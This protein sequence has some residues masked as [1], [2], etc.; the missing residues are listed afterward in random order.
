ML[1][2]LPGVIVA[3]CGPVVQTVEFI[4][5]I[6]VCAI[7]NEYIP[8]HCFK[9]AY[10]TVTCMCVLTF[11]LQLS[12]LSHLMLCYCFTNFLPHFQLGTIDYNVYLSSNRLERE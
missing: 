7:N 5:F 4:S 9:A 12:P 3:P 2:L 8:L 10:L 1:A 6:A 11:G